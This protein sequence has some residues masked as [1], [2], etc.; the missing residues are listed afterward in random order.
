QL[1]P[2]RPFSAE[3][4]GYAIE[5]LYEVTP[6]SDQGQF[7]T[8]LSDLCLSQ[9]FVASYQRISK[10][11]LELAKHLEPIA[12]REVTALGDRDPPEHLVRLLMTVERAER[13]YPD[14][15]G[16]PSL[17]QLVRAKPKLQRALAWCDVAEQRT[18]SAQMN[19][20]TYFWQVI[21]TGNT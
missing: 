17:R 7:L 1:P 2:P 9:P 20:P 12:R 5:S 16:G 4:F 19:D 8:R 21:T 10:R 15:D 3:G 18:N 11:H 13:D 6:K 14:R